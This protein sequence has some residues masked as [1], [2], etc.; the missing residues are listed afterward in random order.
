MEK[1]K[2]RFGIDVIGTCRKYEAG[3]QKKLE[4]GADPAQLLERHLEKLRWL[5][6][7]RLIHLI[8]TALTSLVLMM[9]LILLQI[10]PYTIP[11]LLL[12]VIMLVLTFC[13]L[14][15][16]FRLEN[17]VQHWY[18]IADLLEEKAQAQKK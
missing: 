15:H 9:L 17:T 7:E 4:A 3:L 11:V 18:V 2:D 12:F 5:Q 16:Y 13:Y 6:H 8:V 1:Q 14:V 10:S